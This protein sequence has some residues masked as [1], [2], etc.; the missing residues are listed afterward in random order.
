MVQEVLSFKDI[1]YL[2]LWQVLC[3]V[4]WNHLCNSGRRHE[5][6]SCVII[7]NWDQWFRRKFRLKV[8]LIWKLNFCAILVEDIQGIIL[9]NYLE[10]GWF[11]RCRLKVLSGAL[12]ALLFGGAEPV[13]QF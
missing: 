4:N 5:E 9:C 7:L 2:E 3:S 12:A 10:F 8:F 11:K 6:Q 1:S 13:I